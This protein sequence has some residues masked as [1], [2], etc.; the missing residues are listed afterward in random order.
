MNGTILF[1]NPIR[2]GKVRN[3]VNWEQ[4][5]NGIINIAGQKYSGYSIKEAVYLW[6]KQNKKIN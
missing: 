6:R 2:M 5:R 1:D 4:Y 3:G